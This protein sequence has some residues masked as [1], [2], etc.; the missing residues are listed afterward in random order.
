MNLRRA[1]YLEANHFKNRQE[2]VD[3]LSSLQDPEDP[4]QEDR[5]LYLPHPELRETVPSVCLYSV[6]YK[7]PERFATP[8]ATS[9]S[10]S[11]DNTSSNLDQQLAATVDFFHRCI[12]SQPGF[13]SSVA[14]ATILPDSKL[15]SMAW[16]K[17]YVFFVFEGS[18]T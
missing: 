16:K 9:P 5:P 11:T 8:R 7:L 15:V 12:P 2:E 13:S 1:Y 18:K 4:L 10:S 3:Y 6:L 17:W 14:A